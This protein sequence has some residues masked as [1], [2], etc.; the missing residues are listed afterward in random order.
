MNELYLS[1]TDYSQ[2]KL[3]FQ[4]GFTHANARYVDKT[5]E[6]VAS[7]DFTSS[8]PAVMVLEKFPMSQSI[9]IYNVATEEQAM[10]YLTAY[11]CMLEIELFDVEPKLH[12]ENPLSASK[13]TEKI[14]FTTNNGRIV[15]AG[16]LKTVITEQDYFIYRE[17]Y[18]WN[19]TKS[20]IVWLKVYKKNYLPKP[21][22]N[23]ILGLY[24]MKTELKGVEE[25]KVNYMISK[26]MMNA[27]FGMCVTDPVRDEIEY[28][29]GVYSTTK[30]ILQ[31]AIERYN[32]NVRRFLYYPWGVWITSYARANLFS[33]IRAVGEDYIYSDT[34]SIKLLNHAS[35]AD[36]FNSYNN[37]I[38]DKI[39]KSAAHFGKDVS[40]YSPKNKYGDAKTIGQWDFEGVYD[41]FKTL[42]A[43]RYLTEKGG[44]YSLTVAG[45]SKEY[46]CEYLVKKF[47]SPFDAFND[48]LVI[49]QD[50]SKR[51]TMTYIDEPIEGDMVDCNGVP[52]HYREESCIHG[53]NSAYS[54]SRSE[55]FARFLK[56]VRDI[57][58]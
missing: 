2:L 10:D 16:H 46:A 48:K 9:P 58:E 34:D 19:T 37:H 17:F 15:Y 24:K 30:A 44:T 3:A 32:T 38:I 52:Y 29:D 23:A 41:H 14:D 42:G 36:Y 43:K 4:G 13:C 35:Y 6:S 31:E 49:P 56:G 20:R 40:E 22:V 47:D 8:Y 55:D 7:Y 57:S 27:A 5:L 50:Y 33:G 54:F 11:C 18:N 39:N 53:E 1:P 26:N 51:M 45:V 28:G 25:Q 12:F 21:F